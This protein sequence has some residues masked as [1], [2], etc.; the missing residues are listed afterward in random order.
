LQIAATPLSTQSY[1]MRAETGWLRISRMSQSA[2]ECLLA[3]CCF[4]ELAL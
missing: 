4:S 2:A 3:D 1:G